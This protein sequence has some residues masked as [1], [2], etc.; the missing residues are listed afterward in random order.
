MV[1]RPPPMPSAVN[2]TGVWGSGSRFVIG[3]LGLLGA[4]ACG[5]REPEANHSHETVEQISSPVWV[6]G[7][8]ESDAI[9]V[10]P[11]GWTKETYL[12]QGITQVTPQTLASLKLVTGG[13]AATQIVGGTAESQAD[14]DLGTGASLRYPK[15]GI[16][17]AVLN[18]KPP[19]LGDNYN[20]NALR[21]T[22]TAALGDVDPSDSKVHVRFA[23]A[24]VLQNPNH[25]YTQQP[26]YFVRLQNLTKGITLYQDFNVSAQTGVPW[27]ITNGIYYTDWQV[28]DVAPGNATLAVGDQ[29]E[30]L[31][32]AS[33]CA[34]GGHWGR[35]YVDA[36]GS[37]IPGIYVSATGP[38]SVNTG[39]DITYNVTYANGAGATASGTTVS[40]DVP[41]GTTLI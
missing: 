21:Q 24:P 14:P 22:M 38:Q 31:V 26:Y 35:V 7:G 3:L 13:V 27:K 23:I 16:R 41:T 39:A 33:G 5:P 32:V 8:F 25:G 19:T 6:N 18:Y 10:V 17:S 40:M 9:G 37:S 11:S 20:V 15:Y 12:N 30:I 1:D 4:T 28:V 34:A 36:F 2:R 29:V